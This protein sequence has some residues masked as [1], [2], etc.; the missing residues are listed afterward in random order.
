[1]HKLGLHVLC[2]NYLTFF[3]KL[4]FFFPE[5]KHKMR[6]QSTVQ[7]DILLHVDLI[8]MSTWYNSINELCAE[9]EEK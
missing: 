2:K 7:A 1:M 5:T 3:T 8:L 9:H 6:T 4:C